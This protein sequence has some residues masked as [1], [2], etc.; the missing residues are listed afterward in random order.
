MI[1]VSELLGKRLMALNSAKLIGTV[2]NIVFDEKLTSG[3]LLEVFG[4]EDTDAEIR[5]VELKKVKSLDFDAC[6]IA[7]KSFA[8]PAW[9]ADA[10]GAKNPINCD[11]FNQDGKSLGKVRDVILDGTKVAAVLLDSGEMTPE[12]LISRSDKLIVFNDS[13]KHIKLYR[14]K[15]TVPKPHKANADTAV[16]IHTAQPERTQPPEPQE[17]QTN[18]AL[19]ARVPQTNTVVTRTP[20]KDE[21]TNPYAFL[22]GKTLVKDISADNGVVLLRRHSVI[23]DEII[24]AARQHG[25]LVQLAL[26]AE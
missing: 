20:A 12:K 8:L 5:Y 6:V 10:N 26:Y 25:K 2:G 7:D 3:R 11:C 24:S 19:P 14:P 13:G 21:I 23:T 22:I 4:D 17:N 15:T 9:A 18:I 16:K 1:K